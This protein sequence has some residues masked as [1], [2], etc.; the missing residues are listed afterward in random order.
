[1]ILILDIDGTLADIRHR[2][3][4][5]DKIKPTSKDWDAYFTPELVILDKP[6]LNT[7][8]AVKKLKTQF[9]NLIFLTGRPESLRDATVIWLNEYYHILPNEHTLFMRSKDALDTE[10]HL[11]R[12][13]F[14]SA[15]F[16]EEILP[17]YPEQKFTFIDDDV[18]IL[19]T[20][21]GFGLAIKA[22]ECWQLFY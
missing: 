2:L 1:M 19:K 15:L 3:P 13:K 21:A 4:L 7:Q 9:D 20:L 14:K 6:I 17:L 16:Q 18:V 12:A 11:I 10:D 5:I 22:P 8:R